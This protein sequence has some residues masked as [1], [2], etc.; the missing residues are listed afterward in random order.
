MHVLN[1]NYGSTILQP[2]MSEHVTVSRYSTTIPQSRAIW[3]CY[4]L[5]RARVVIMWTISRSRA[6]Q[7]YLMIT[8]SKINETEHLWHWV[9]GYLSFRKK[10]QA[11]LVLEWPTPPP[12]NRMKR[13][14]S[15]KLLLLSVQV[16]LCLNQ[17]TSWHNKGRNLY[18]LQMVNVPWKGQE[19]LPSCP[20]CQD[21]IHGGSYMVL[22]RAHRLLGSDCPMVVSRDL[23]HSHVVLLTRLV[24]L[25]YVL[26]LA[27]AFIWCMGLY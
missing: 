25:C 26:P 11:S 19:D 5:M 17:L 15:A 20:H 8:S 7:S 18:C 24:L 2:I 23:S 4:P 1:I 10:L 14:R 9:W 27:T 12:K 3:W 6:L 21:P 22:G 16:I 13:S